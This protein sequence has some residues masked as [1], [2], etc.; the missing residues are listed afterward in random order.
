MLLL[1]YQTAQRN[2]SLSVVGARLEMVAM[3]LANQATVEVIMVVEEAVV[4][5]GAMIEATKTSTLT[6]R[7]EL[8]D[9]ACHLHPALQLYVPSKGSSYANHYYLAAVYH[10]P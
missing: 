1:V 7:L 3:D 2:R 5:V 6:L 10:R 4:M 9:A 8:S